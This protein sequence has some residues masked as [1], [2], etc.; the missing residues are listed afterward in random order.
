MV[1]N[2]GQILKS[3]IWRKRNLTPRVHFKEVVGIPSVLE[4]KHMLQ[5]FLGLANQI[6]EYVSNLAKVINRL[7]KKVSSKVPWDWTNEDTNY[8]IRS[9]NLTKN[10]QYLT[11]LKD[12]DSMIIESNASNLYWGRIFKPKGI[13]NINE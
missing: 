2:Y 5:Q 7:T 4:S 13:D 10:I 8:V 3:G 12:S 9:K 11:L 1:S 6:R